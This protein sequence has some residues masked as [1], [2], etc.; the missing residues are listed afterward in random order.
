MTLNQWQS[1]NHIYSYCHRTASLVP[2]TS[3]QLLSLD[4]CMHLVFTFPCQLEYAS[5][6]TAK[7][8]QISGL[9]E[10]MGRLQVLYCVMLASL[11]YRHTIVL[12][13]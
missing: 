8:A 6:L 2:Q 9:G 13:S 12:S 3:P 1:P 4:S 11:F 7:D 10:E 5:Q